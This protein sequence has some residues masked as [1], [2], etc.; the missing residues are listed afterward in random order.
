MAIAFRPTKVET[1]DSI[2]VFTDEGL[3]TMSLATDIRQLQ[4][5]KQDVFQPATVSMKSLIVQS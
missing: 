1:V 5:E 4:S 3:I 2:Q